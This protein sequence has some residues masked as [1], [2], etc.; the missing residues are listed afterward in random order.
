MN[1]LDAFRDQI[2]SSPCR[3]QEQLQYLKRRRAAARSNRAEWREFRWKIFF[4]VANTV[5]GRD[6]RPYPIG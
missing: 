5:A 4:A 2:R 1:M 3:R 6:D